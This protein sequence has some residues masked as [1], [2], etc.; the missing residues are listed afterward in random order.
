MG[1]SELTVELK[2]GLPNTMSHAPPRHPQHLPTGTS[3]LPVD[4]AVRA[5]S[6]PGLETTLRTVRAALDHRRAIAGPPPSPDGWIRADQLLD[7]ATLDEALAVVRDH[8]Q[9]T[10]EVAVSYFTAWYAATIV[11][12]AIAMFVLT[13]RVPDLDPAGISVH[14]HEGGWFDSTAFHRPRLALL[15]SDPALADH[16]DLLDAEVSVELGGTDPIEVTRVAADVDALRAQLVGQI[17]GHLEPVINSLRSR[18]RLGHAALW[19]AVASQCGRAFLLTERVSGDPH[20]GRLEADAFFADAAPTLRARPTWQQFVHHGRTY[21]GMRRGSCC[22][23]HRLTEEFCTACPFVATDE[24]EHRL[25]EWIDA[26]GPGG[27][28]V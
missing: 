15:R 4:L 27:L 6:L 23:A 17:I 10:A 21:T 16:L 8:N 2:L 12:P 9:A 14:C 26:Q 19:G 5:T 13:R 7:P 24:R 20:I 1:D 3:G 25:R 18:A 28:A 11:G 22:L